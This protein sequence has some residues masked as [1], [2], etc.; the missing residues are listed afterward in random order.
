MT[1]DRDCESLYVC[2]C[3]EMVVS[4]HVLLT[5]TG[6]AILLNIR[7]V[8][9][10]PHNMHPEKGTIYYIARNVTGKQTSHLIYLLGKC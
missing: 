8:N 5:V 6:W 9:L 7:C 3:F 10:I 4:I 1:D 2:M